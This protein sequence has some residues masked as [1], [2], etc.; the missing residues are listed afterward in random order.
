[1]EQAI[2]WPMVRSKAVAQALHLE[3][4]EDHQSVRMVVRLAATVVAR[5]NRYELV[6]VARIR[7][8]EVGHTRRSVLVLVAVQCVQVSM[9]TL[10]EDDLECYTKMA[11]GDAKAA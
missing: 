8:V 1:L 3:Q 11:D 7:A 4:I 2:D 5:S 10:E 9:Q 6:G